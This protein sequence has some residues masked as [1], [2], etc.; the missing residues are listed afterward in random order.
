[1]PFV[2]EDKQPEPQFPTWVMVALMAA[3]SSVTC[4]GFSLY[5]PTARPS[6]MMVKTAFGE[7]L[8][9]QQT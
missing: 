4:E 1:M 6:T 2:D 8:H 3:V 7:H 9:L 5:M